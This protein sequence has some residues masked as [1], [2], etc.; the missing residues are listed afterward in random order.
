MTTLDSSRGV[1][2]KKPWW[3]F[4]EMPSGILFE[5]TTENTH[6]LSVLLAGNVSMASLS[7]SQQQ[8]FICLNCIKLS[9][10]ET[11]AL[12][13]RTAVAYLVSCTGQSSHQETTWG[14][15]RTKWSVPLPSACHA[16]KTELFSHQSR[17][18]VS[19]ALLAN[20]PPAQAGD[21]RF[22]WMEAFEIATE[23]QWIA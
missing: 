11:P 4:N 20:P 21:K 23:N 1:G 8:L 13:L 22:L 12:Y 7:I 17:T 2:S 16:D 9:W 5:E 19:M 15:A 14:W 18:Q 10:K 6:M 3:N